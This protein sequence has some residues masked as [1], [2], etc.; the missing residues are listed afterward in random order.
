MESPTRTAHAAH[1][2]PPALA[3]LERELAALRAT[4]A[5]AMPVRAMP[6]RGVDDHAAVRTEHV[7]GPASAVRVDDERTPQAVP[8]R[9]RSVSDRRGHERLVPDREGHERSM[10]DRGGRERSMPAPG[11]R[12]RAV[13]D[14]GGR[15]RVAA[16]PTTT[17]CSAL[18]DDVERMSDAGLVRVTD[19]LAKL[20]RD[21]DAA[22]ARVAAEVAKR[23]EP[24]LGQDGLARAHGF[25]NPT[26]LIAASTGTSRADA[27][28]LIAVGSATAERSTFRGERAPSRHPHVGAALAA[29]SISVEAASAITSTL[30]RASARADDARVDRVESALVELAARVPLE[31]LM[32]GVREA[33][34]QL[35]PGGVEP[36]EDALRAER[37]LTMRQD[38][39]GM[40]HLHA[41][42]DP[43]SAA[44]VKAA[45][46]ALA[47]DALRRRE[48]AHAAQTPSPVVADERSI[49]Q[50]QADALAALARHSLGCPEAA[51]PLAKATVVVR[52][53]LETLV[54][55]LGHARID[56]L[57]QPISAGTARRMAADA[58]L[59]PAVLGGQ[60]LP[61]DL[62]RS[63]RLFTKAQRLALGERDG[64]CA[65]CGQD[66]GYVEAHHIDWWERDAGPTDLSNGV[67]L[68]SF[69]HHVIHRDGWRIHAGPSEVRFIPPPHLDPEQVPRVGGRARFE[70]RD[71]LAA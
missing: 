22:L 16:P 19:A 39:R 58:E 57:D 17:H 29:A 37:S 43:E 13:P 46:E 65:S 59:I 7:G 61:L 28:R 11:V 64:G 25:H 31:T 24:E 23:S 56:G 52:V 44:P 45:L 71:A 20:R 30:D 8:P 41:R 66:I 53:D 68:C 49:P 54:T 1:A 21:V 36:R 69:C 12:E 6:V 63:A 70:V 40:V 5:G 26:R 42:L 38:A 60:S 55:G 51:A 32:R 47:S 27:A 48:P 3:A 18:Q 33:E 9:E 4:W 15:E 50:I 62:G 14:P 67:L 10:P 2:A 34:A 35:D